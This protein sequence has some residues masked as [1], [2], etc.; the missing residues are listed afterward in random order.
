MLKKYIVPAVVAATLAVPAFAQDTTS[1]SATG[2]GSSFTGARA[3]VFGGYLHTQSRFRGGSAATVTGNRNASTGTA[4][5]EL[6]Y[7]LPIGDRFV[8]GPLASFSLN[9]TPAGSCVGSATACV[10]P[11]MDWSAG[12]RVGAKMGDKA[13]I[14]A[15]GAYV[16]TRSGSRQLVASTL[17]N[18]HDWKSGWRAGVGA[19][20]AVSPHAYVKAEYDYTRTG[21]ENLD[22]QG[23]P[24]TNVRLERQAAL[25]GFGVRF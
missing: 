8:A 4:G 7:D 11:E 1:A 3:E 6:G 13:L 14:Y 18:G 12:G 21:R 22:Q 10:K 17:V 23:M 25:A 24:G 5:V 15:K 20:Y 9:T 2:A 19:E 16:D